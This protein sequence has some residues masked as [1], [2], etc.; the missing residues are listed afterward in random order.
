MFE[1]YLFRITRKGKPLAPFPGCEEEMEYTQSTL[2]RLSILMQALEYGEN[3]KPWESTCQEVTNEY[4][5]RRKEK[6]NAKKYD[7]GDTRRDDSGSMPILGVFAAGVM[8]GASGILFVE[9]VWK[10]WFGE[11][12]YESIVW[13]KEWH[14]RALNFLL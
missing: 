8:L 14:T 7:D 11:W 6:K 5:E 10:K 4:H 2:C 9:R 13:H 12:K 1:N 3:I